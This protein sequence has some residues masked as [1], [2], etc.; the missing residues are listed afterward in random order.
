MEH[1]HRNI[2][3]KIYQTF[4]N[5]S[6]CVCMKQVVDRNNKTIRYSVC[7]QMK[8]NDSQYKQK[9]VKDRKMFDGSTFK[10]KCRRVCVC[11]WKRFIH[12]YT[13]SERERERYIQ[14]DRDIIFSG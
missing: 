4:L 13:Q 3:E 9:K 1:R 2:K 8:K 10:W 5:H 12:I 14:N 6:L 7:L 11:V